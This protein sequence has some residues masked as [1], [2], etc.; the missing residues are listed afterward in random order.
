MKSIY[1]HLNIQIQS[2]NTKHTSK[3]NK[4]DKIHLYLK[5]QIQSAYTKQTRNNKQGQ[6]E[7]IPYISSETSTKCLDL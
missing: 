5:L 6:N 3:T 2:V 4:E 1:N 7:K